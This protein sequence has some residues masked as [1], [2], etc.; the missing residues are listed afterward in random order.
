[1]KK[2]LRFVDK[3][4]EIVAWV[5]IALIAVLA[6]M[7]TADVL[8]RM[9][10]G[11][12]MKG[13]YEIAQFLLC[14]ISFMAYPL[15]QVRRGH[16]HVG[17]IVSRFP[18]KARYLLSAFSFLWS[19]V[20]CGIVSYALWTQGVFTLSS[21]KLTQVLLLPYYPVYYASSVLMG[22]FAI[23]LLTDVVRSILA[24]LGDEECQKSIQKVYS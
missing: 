24:F 11:Q 6:L 13:T 21:N 7:Y 15:A 12:Q 5:G 17:F 23:T 4:S 22:I 8:G 20:M 3:F 16:I 19:V 14:L 9:L 2:A 10:L 1:M 18:P